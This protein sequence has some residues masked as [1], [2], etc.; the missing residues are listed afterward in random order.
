MSRLT[1]GPRCFLPV[2][3]YHPLWR[4]FPS[5]SRSYTLATGLVRVRSPLLTESRLMS[6]PLGT[7]MFQ[8]SRFAS[9][10]LYIQDRIPPKRWVSPFRNPRIKGYSHLPVAYRSVLRLSSPLSAKASTKCPYH[11][12]DLFPACPDIISQF[13]VRINIQ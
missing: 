6:F 4:T 13:I 3:G 11:S 12:L 8:F 5:P 9:L 2:R 10:S 7:E 1:R